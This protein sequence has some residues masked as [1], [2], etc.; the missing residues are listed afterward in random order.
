MYEKYRLYKNYAIIGIIS[1][2]L[3]GFL[4]FV[5]SEVGLAFVLPTTI[6]GWIV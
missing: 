1:V 4:P 5:G 2:L 3:L 6:A